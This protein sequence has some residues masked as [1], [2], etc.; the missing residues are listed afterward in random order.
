MASTNPSGSPSSSPWENGQSST[1]SIRPG[2]ASGAATMPNSRDDPVSRYRPGRGSSSTD[3]LMASSSSFGAR[4]ISS[5]TSS[6]EESTKPTGSAIAA[7]RPCARSRSRRSARRSPATMRTSVLLPAWR[8]PL[9]STTRVSHSAALACAAARRGITYGVGTHPGTQDAFDL[10]EVTL[11]ICG[12]LM[13]GMRTFGVRFAAK[14]PGS[15]RPAAALVGRG[16][17]SAPFELSRR[18]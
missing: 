17:R 16:A 10:R 12:S 3:A 4:W 2:N 7:A 18:E 14:K 1:V 13:F 8:A 6:S 11:A 9:I 5:M 15:R